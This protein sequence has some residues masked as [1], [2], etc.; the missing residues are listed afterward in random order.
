MR[1]PTTAIRGDLVAIGATKREAKANLEDLISWACENH[2]LRIEFRF[3]FILIIA[4]TANGYE[5]ALIDPKTIKPDENYGYGC[6]TTYGQIEVHDVLQ[7]LRNHAAQNAWTLETD[8]A[9][10]ILASG[11]DQRHCIDLQRWIDWQRHYAR[12][13]SE[14]M[15]DNDAYNAAHDAMHAV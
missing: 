5:S 4:A 10:H 2:A 9:A 6:R 15:N 3:G 14:G 7:S 11:L 1:K 12:L 13:R 8:D